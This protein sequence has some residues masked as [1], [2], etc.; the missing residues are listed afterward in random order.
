[1]VEVDGVL[2]MKQSRSMACSGAG[3]GG[4]PRVKRLRS[5]ACSGAGGGD[6]L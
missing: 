1:V 3:R 6:M 2:Q 5:T 4:V